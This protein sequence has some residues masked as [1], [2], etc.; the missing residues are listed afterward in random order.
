[1]KTGNLYINWVPFFLLQTL[2]LEDYPHN[3]TKYEMN[4]TSK[5]P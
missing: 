4:G 5:I 1:M 3:L 2:R